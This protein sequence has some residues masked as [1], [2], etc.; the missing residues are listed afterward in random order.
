MLAA[1][2][3]FHG[4]VSAQPAERCGTT[5]FALPGEL[6]TACD[7]CTGTALDIVF[8]VDASRSVDDPAYGGVPGSFQ[9]QLNFVRD[10]V[11]QLTHVSESGARVALV[12]F[13]TTAE[14]AFSFGDHAFSKDAI[15]DAIVATPRPAPGITN[16]HLAFQTVREQL[17]LRS[18]AGGHFSTSAAPRTGRTVVFT[19][20]DF[21][22]KESGDTDD[23]GLRA[24][25]SELAKMDALLA[26]GGSTPERHA[27][28]I[29]T[30]G[31]EEEERIRSLVDQLTL[32]G[33]PQ[34]LPSTRPDAAPRPSL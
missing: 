14:V 27:I 13:S 15:L 20:T 25:E 28:G 12:T 7:F 29:T 19:I 32:V 6:C 22:F 24:L 11:Q 34:W 18:A 8:V 30:A 4:L 10:A 21:T 1:S 17:L 16:L 2:M 23:V 31:A 5:E 26:A 33:R 3:P 9:R